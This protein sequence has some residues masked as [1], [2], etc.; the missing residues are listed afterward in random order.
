MNLHFDPFWHF[1]ETRIPDTSTRIYW[2]DNAAATFVECAEDILLANG[3]VV[4]CSRTL[5]PELFS[6][7]PHSYGTLGYVRL[8]SRVVWGSNQLFGLH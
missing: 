2:E 1:N 5:H 7:L 4:H 6:A 3:T 8:P